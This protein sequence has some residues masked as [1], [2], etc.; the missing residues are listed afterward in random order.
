[1][2]LLTRYILIT[3]CIISP[4]SAQEYRLEDTGNDVY[5]YVAGNYRSVVINTSD[6]IVV[7][8]P[9]NT[10]AANWLKKE[11][12]ERFNKPVRY[13]IYSHSHPDHSYGGN[14]FDDGN[15]V[16]ISHEDARANLVRTKAQ[17]TIPKLVFSD[18]FILHAGESSIEMRYL[19]PNNGYG[20]V[21]IRIQ[22]GNILMV[23]DWITLGRLPY[24]DLMG[25]DIEGMI[26]SVEEVL[27]QPFNLFIGGHADTGSYR[28]VENYRNYLV[29]LHDTVLEGILAGKSLE[30]IQTTKALS[31]WSELKMFEE[32]MPLNIEG[33]YNQLMSRS[34]IQLRPE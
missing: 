13:V 22:P 26:V 2:S 32:W 31:P 34:Y 11:V 19:G 24:K 1:M 3:I 20:N 7:V 28:D 33:V 29:T 12:K 30:E 10:D 14:V 8:D 27:K 9:L 5:R 18:T 15:T 6:G 4:A 16:F 21:A 25:Y 23:T 17:T